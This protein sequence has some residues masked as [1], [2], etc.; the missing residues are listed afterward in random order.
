MAE[1][2]L[3]MGVGAYR[4]EYSQSG[5]LLWIRGPAGA[6]GPACRDCNGETRFT[7]RV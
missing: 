1:H 7:A 4:F 2:H 6:G 3:L 5:K